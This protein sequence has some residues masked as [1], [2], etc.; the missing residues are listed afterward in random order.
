MPLFMDLKVGESLSVE[1]DRIVVTLEEK[2]GQRARLAVVADKS[3]NIEHKKN[4]HV[5][6]KGLSKRKY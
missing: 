2:S 1:N 5:A 6:V 3:I 4:P